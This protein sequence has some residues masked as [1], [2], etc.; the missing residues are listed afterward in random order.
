MVMIELVYCKITGKTRSLPK[1]LILYFCTW[2][3]SKQ[4]FLWKAVDICFIPTPARTGVLNLSV[5]R[6][7]TLKN[8][9]HNQSFY[10]F[11]LF[12][13]IFFGIRGEWECVF[14]SNETKI[15]KKSNFQA[16]MISMPQTLYYVACHL[17]MD[18]NAWFHDTL[19]GC[20]LFFI[21]QK[22]Y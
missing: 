5:F 11:S 14:I 9:L 20:E 2:T 22:Y 16:C 21:W 8:T 18:L 7:Y 17:L 1:E 19:I 4:S 10:L 13:F 12:F 15:N 3:M 6:S